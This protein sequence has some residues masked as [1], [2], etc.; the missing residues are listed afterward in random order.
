MV[1]QSSSTRIKMVLI[2]HHED[3][4]NR[5]AVARWLASFTDLLGVIS[6]QEP[7]GRLWKRIR[8]EMQRVGW[9]RFADV[10]AFRLYY[11]LFLAAKDGQWRQ[12]T[13]AAME[14]RYAPLPDSCE[15]LTTPSPNS[16][17]AEAM[18]SRLQPDLVLARC[19]TLLSK[20]IFTIPRCAT[21]VMHPG[22]CP[23]YR[24]AHGCFWALAKRDVNRVGMTLLRI[25]AGVDTGP[26]YGYYTYP[27]NEILESHIVIQE[28]VVLE[29]L[30]ALESKMNE[31]V[32][33]R[34]DRIDTSARDSRAWGQ[35]WLSAYWRWKR[36][37]RR[38]QT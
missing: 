34:A 6:I 38:R 22:I 17:E 19:K 24:N 1:A 5:I 8:R 23:E 29:N 35:P 36:A 15:I 33:Q 31:I 13:V 20:R 28:R 30:S 25:D 9:W 18:L 11:R 3:P 32:Q 4:I 21:L 7:G 2:C 14:R 16:P 10:L 27:Y 37:A 12:E 26:V